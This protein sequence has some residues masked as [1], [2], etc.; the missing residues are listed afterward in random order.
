MTLKKTGT[1]QLALMICMALTSALIGCSPKAEQ[2][3]LTSGASDG[4]GTVAQK[5][6]SEA[7]PP[8]STD[9]GDPIAGAK[10]LVEKANKTEKFSDM[11]ELFTNE[12]AAAFALP[13]SMMVGLVAGMGE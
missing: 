6:P 3:N 11:S 2:A 12:S 1:G 9:P 8:V 10:A 13:V 5:P 7:P 4:G